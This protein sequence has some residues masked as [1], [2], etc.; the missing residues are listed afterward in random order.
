MPQAD[1]DSN[2]YAVTADVSRRRFLAATATTAAVLSVDLRLS[3]CASAAVPESLEIHSWITINADNRVTVRIPQSE[4]GQGATTAL[5]QIMADELDLEL[6]LTDW[7]FYDPQTNVQRDNVYVHTPTLASWGIKMLFQ[8]MR[9]AGANIRQLLLNAAAEALDVAPADLELGNH[10][11]TTSTG[12][13]VRYYDLADRVQAA[14]LPTDAQPKRP[15][16]WRY[17]GRAIARNDA[18]AK[19]TGAAEYGIDVRLPGMKYAAVKQCPVFGGRLRGFDAAAI[20]DRPGILKVVAIK[21]G[22][23]GYTVP[24]TLWDVI[25]WEMDDAVAVVAD[26]WWQA[27]QALNDLPIE[28]DEGPNAAVDSAEIERRLENALLQEGEVVHQQGD[29]AAAFDSAERIIEATYDYPFME[30]APMEPMNCTALVDDWKVEA[31]GP[32]QYGDEAL[33]IAAYAAGIA[34][35]DARF[36]LTLAGGGFGRRL[37]NDYVS[38]AVQV[39]KQL[40]GTPVK[41][42]WSREE[43]TQRSYYPPPL[44]VKFRAALDAN[45]ELRGWHSHVAQGRAVFQ[46]YG[47]S[48]VGFATGATQVNYSAVDTP[49][50]FAWMRGVGNTQMWWMNHSF[51]GEIAAARGLSSLE[52]QLHL[53]DERYIERERA[54]YDDAIGRVRRF[55]HLLNT[56]ADKAG[57]VQPAARGHGRGFAVFDASYMPGYKNSCIALAVDVVLDGAGN[58]D[59]TKVSAVVDCGTAVNPDIVKA[60]I[61]G[62]TMFGLS[63]ALFA[64]ISLSE[65]RVE[66]SNFHDYPVLKLAAAPDIDVEIMPSD[67]PP[68]GVGEGAT[69]IIIAALVDAIYAAG[70][71][72]IRSLPVMDNDLRLREQT[73]S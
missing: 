45:A 42:L 57:R 12:Q 73:S 28:W 35:K 53:L 24:Q 7:E 37:H 47:L 32:S 50:A 15:D 39:A 18:E 2:N 63:N 55:R 23:S 19:S 33:R 11:I 69:P 44:K 59:V 1:P 40:P 43:N 31:W 64:R 10:R 49:P 58:I 14:A 61:T 54:D 67:A 56:V 21:A 46:P 26:S 13:S 34:L 22:P 71:P 41:L 72:R 6:G 3:W 36:H 17:I 29:V 51:L 4:I 16:Q 70:G 27:Q 65:G 30:H 48:R 66:Q 20:A 38:Q 8:P 9:Q 5:M 52:H 68:V 25:D 62:G 60:Q